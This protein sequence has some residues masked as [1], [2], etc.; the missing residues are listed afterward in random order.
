MCD[1]IT[2]GTP[3]KT[4]MDNYIL[5][6]L[7]SYNKKYGNSGKSVSNSSVNKTISASSKIS[8]LEDA[9]IYEDN[10]LYIY[11][12]MLPITLIL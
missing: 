5:S 12:E 7:Y 10:S 3:S 4:A 2:S 1:T 6:I 8:D 11:D 9:E